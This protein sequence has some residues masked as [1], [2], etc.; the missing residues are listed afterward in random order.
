MPGFAQQSSSSEGAT[1][2]GKLR[3]ETIVWDWNGTLLDDV[4]LAIRV[5]NDLLVEHGHPTLDQ[6]TYAH[7]FEFPVQRYYETIG[8]DLET[9]D[10]ASL[11]TRFC[12]AFEAGLVAQKREAELFPDVNTVLSELHRHA[13]F[14]LSNTEQ[15]ALDRMLAEY[16]LTHHFEGIY[17]LGNNRATG[18]AGIGE[19]LVTAHVVDRDRTILIGDT[20]HDADVAKTLGMDCLLVATGHNARHRLE[21]AGVPVVDSLREIPEHLAVA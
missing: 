20:T 10:F 12:D 8:F 16:E 17:G 14:I 3:Y 9:H 5:M 18:K 2:R 21:A 15:T 7:V 11:S 13:H 19:D 6:E 4:G 1:T